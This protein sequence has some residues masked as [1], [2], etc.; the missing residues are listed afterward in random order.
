MLDLKCEYPDGCKLDLWMNVVKAKFIEEETILKDRYCILE[1]EVGGKI[2][3]I[4]DI[5]IKVLNTSYTFNSNSITIYVEYKVVMVV[6]VEDEEE[7]VTITNTYEQ[8]I[9]LDQFDPPLTISEFKSEVDQAEII[10]KNWDTDADIL[11]D[12]IDPCDS[13]FFSPV[14]GTLIK[15]HI[16]A[17]IVVKLSKMHDTIVYGEIDP[18]C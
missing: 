10:L 4:E 6:L 18:E 14:P 9:K 12:C 3:S 16:S 2:T 8:T 17:C 11:G 7:V 15:I 1:S 13:S 5:R